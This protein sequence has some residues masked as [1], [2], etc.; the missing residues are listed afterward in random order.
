[1]KGTINN[2]ELIDNRHEPLPLW[3]WIFLQIAV[4]YILVSYFV[5]G[6]IYVGER[7]EENSEQKF[8]KNLKIYWQVG[9]IDI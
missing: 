2:A 3:F 6:W 5:L 4:H 1:M 8:E 7:D 9:R